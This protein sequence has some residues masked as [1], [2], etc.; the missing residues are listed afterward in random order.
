MVVSPS[1]SETGH[2]SS[3]VD[4]SDLPSDVY[5][6]DI[7]DHNAATSLAKTDPPAYKSSYV[8]NVEQME[9]GDPPNYNQVGCHPTSSET[10]PSN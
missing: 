5:T 10:T 4:S 8:L 1:N 3:S 2:R 6:I 9:G 7:K